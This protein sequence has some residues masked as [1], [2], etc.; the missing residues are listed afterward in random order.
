MKTMLKM[1]PHRAK[2]ILLNQREK[3]F[4]KNLPCLMCLP[5]MIIQC[6]EVEVSLPLPLT[7]TTLMN[8]T[9]EVSAMNQPWWSIPLFAKMA[10][11]CS[12]NPKLWERRSKILFLHISAPLYLRKSPLNSSAFLTSRKRGKLIWSP[13]IS[14]SPMSM[15]SQK[16]WVWKPNSVC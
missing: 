7:I 10:V 5:A 3:A 12:R 16:V 11:A 1:R 4:L 13:S 9:Q 8:S 6:K 14:E 2:C 15:P